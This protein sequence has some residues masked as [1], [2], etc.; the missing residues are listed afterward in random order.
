MINTTLIK[1]KLVQVYAGLM[2]VMASTGVATAGTFDNVTTMLTDL[3]GIFT[4]ILDI[5]VAVIPIMIA[6]AI[7]TFVIGLLSSILGK[8]RGKM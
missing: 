7:A 5:V 8:I 3:V 2:A 6:L 1:A 4:P